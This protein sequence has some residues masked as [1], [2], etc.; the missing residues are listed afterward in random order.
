MDFVVWAKIST[1][2]MRQH[3]DCL[4]SAVDIVLQINVNDGETHRQSLDRQQWRLV[5]QRFRGATRE[6]N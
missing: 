3:C 6:K 2:L 4:F 5:T 1:F